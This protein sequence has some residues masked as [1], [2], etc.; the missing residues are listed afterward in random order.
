MR[1][2][3]LQETIACLC[4]LCSQQSLEYA[5]ASRQLLQM[6]ADKI[7][8]LFLGQASLGCV[9][10]TSKLYVNGHA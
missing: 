3:L 1:V 5:A 4:G 8:L 10:S 9:R 6:L 2:S 7:M